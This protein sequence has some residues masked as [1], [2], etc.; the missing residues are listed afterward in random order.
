MKNHLFIAALLLI[1][2]GCS[3]PSASATKENP[4]P[5][6]IEV[7]QAS[8]PARALPEGVELL[9]SP[10]ISREGISTTGDSRAA[11]TAIV[12]LGEAELMSPASRGLIAEIREEFEADVR[13]VIKPILRGKIGQ[14]PRESQFLRAVLAADRQDAFWPFADH[15]LAEREAWAG[16][17]R[18][19]EIEPPRE[20]I[21]QWVS[22]L[23]LDRERFDRDFDDPALM[24]TVLANTSEAH[25]YGYEKSLGISLNGNKLDLSSAIFSLQMYDAQPWLSGELEYAYARA[26]DTIKPAFDAAFAQARAFLDS[27]DAPERLYL[28]LVERN[29][30]QRATSH[31][32]ALIALL[33][34][35]E[36]DMITGTSDAPLVTII[37]LCMIDRGH[38]HSKLTRTLVEKYGDEVQIV[39]WPRTRRYSRMED[40]SL[41]PKAAFAATTLGHYNEMRQAFDELIGPGES[42]PDQELLAKTAG[43]DALALE[44]AMASEAFRRWM[45]H[46]HYAME[47]ARS[48]DSLATL[49][50]VPILVINGIAISGQY[51]VNG[52]GFLEQPPLTA[53]EE[54]VELQ[55]ELARH[56]KAR[57][58]KSGPELYELLVELNSEEPPSFEPFERDIVIAPEY[59]DLTGLPYQGPEDAVPVV[60]FHDFTRLAAASHKALREAII[61]HDGDVRLYWHPAPRDT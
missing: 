51:N 4:S 7:A 26:M 16:L 3:T 40:P 23:E 27:D 45:G 21:A 1:G 48:L 43:L 12:Y 56:I 35:A 28:E 8:D 41:L 32:E 58:G 37:E 57:T 54:L 53:V 22:D 59:L 33:S 38:C 61:D 14:S 50:G 46:T 39:F 19:T 15:A 55:L 42:L 36:V 17:G 13:F 29:L 6:T 25:I 2:A 30:A 44:E 5:A 24:Q 20:L 47:K 31:T 60:V 52:L 49:A 9:D 18:S 34:P 11:V 10:F